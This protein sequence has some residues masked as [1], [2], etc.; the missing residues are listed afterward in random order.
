MLNVLM[1]YAVLVIG[2][3]SCRLSNPVYAFV[4]YEIIYFFHPAKRWWGYMVPDLSYS[5][6]IVIT[7]ISLTILNA[8]E[9]NKNKLLATPQFKW[10]YILLFIYAISYFVAVYPT[11]HSAATINFLKLVIIISV[12]YKICDTERKLDYLLYGYIFGAWYIGFVA[13]QVGRNAGDRV[14]G[15]GTVD[16]PDSNGIAAA[17][18]P[19]LV[20]CL[21]YFWMNKT[22][23]GKG[24]VAVAGAF[25][26][27]GLVLINSRGA[28][29]GACA[30]IGLFMAYM[31]FSPIKRKSQKSIAIY[32][33]IFGLIGLLSMVDESTMNRFSSIS[34]SEM[35]EE[36]ETGAT[37]VFFWLAAWEMA[38]DH[39]LGA[40]NRSFEYYAPIYIPEEVNTG[41]HR[42]RAV[43]STWMETLSEVGY[44]GLFVFI[45]LMYSTH[46]SLQQCKKVLRNENRVDEYFKI[47]AIQA[48]FLSFLIAMTFLNRMRAEILY[49]II[50]YAAIAYN[51]YV[52]KPSSSNKEP[53]LKGNDK[54]ADSSTEK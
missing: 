26:A 45:M 8:K 37:R 9:I 5:F 52:L 39:P 50:L 29:L 21:Y 15:I 3:A 49:W 20:L 19:S 24:L 34:D 7:M 23:W 41:G 46:S 40:G 22:W 33:T 44:L 1:F 47:I 36:S 35:T 12:A 32:I 31:Y 30:S 27:N 11:N 38:K 17:I 14:E 48:A 28:F 4:L 2:F 42:N 16:A 25:V 54:K 18:A 13:Y 10:I 51:V 43:H 6:F 53:E